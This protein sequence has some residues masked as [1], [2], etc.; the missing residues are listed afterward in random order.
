MWIEKYNQLE[1][2]DSLN[3]LVN[4]KEEHIEKKNEEISLCFENEKL[5][6]SN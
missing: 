6:H 5:I 2:V 1:I 3:N 4:G